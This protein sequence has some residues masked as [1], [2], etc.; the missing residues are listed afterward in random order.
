MSAHRMT[1]RNTRP[2]SRGTPHPPELLEI[3]D[4]ERE[5]IDMPNMGI[6]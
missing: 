6:G 4:V 5:A 2:H 3:I 1:D